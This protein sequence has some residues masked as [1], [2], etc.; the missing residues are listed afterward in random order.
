MSYIDVRD[1]AVV[2]AG[3]L[4]DPAGHLGKT[5]ELNGPEALTQTQIAEKISRAC[6]RAV[7]YIDIPVEAQR[8]A[9]LDQGMPEWQV[10]ALLDLQAYYMQGH[11]GATDGVLQGLLKRAPITVDDFLVEFRE[12][13]RD[14]AARA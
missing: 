4:R 13:F 12:T 1:I 3:A 5:Y 11:G 14:A 9:M 2:I 6:G 8:K 10:N 7:K